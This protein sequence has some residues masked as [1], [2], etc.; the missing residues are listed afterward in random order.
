MKIYTSFLFTFLFLTVFSCKKE[1]TEPDCPAPCY[2]QYDVPG[3]PPVTA[4]GAGT[5]GFL[6]N[7]EPWVAQGSIPGGNPGP[8]FAAYDEATGF[9]EIVFYKVITSDEDDFI[10]RF[11]FDI[12]SAFY[13]AEKYNITQGNARWSDNQDICD[14]PFSSIIGENNHVEI[15]NLNKEENKLSCLFS[16]ILIQDDCPGDTIKITNG[17]VDTNYLPY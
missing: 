15:L 3:L 8:I 9:L 11:K 1:Q 10:Q 16:C 2:A 17:R 7:G 12:S 14:Y 4:S 5:A 6:L 13:V